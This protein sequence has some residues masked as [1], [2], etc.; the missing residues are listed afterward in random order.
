MSGLFENF[1]VRIER[2]TEVL[3]GSGT[4][5]VVV[6]SPEEQVLGDADY[7]AAKMAELRMP[8]KG[9][10]MN[11]VHPEVR[12]RT[13][14]GIDADDTEAVTG[15]VAAAVGPADASGLAANF[16]AYQ[17]LARGEHLRIEQ[18]RAGLPK[19]VP[20]VVVPNFSRDVHDLGTLAALHPYLFG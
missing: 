11:R 17:T 14:G 6:A 12:A 3:R 1:H 2:A 10:V 19:R 5:F 8:L 4:A 16:A 20:F 15:L 7:L 9:L 13:R 18:F